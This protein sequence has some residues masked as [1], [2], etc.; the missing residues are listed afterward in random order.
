MSTG[1][2]CRES[3]WLLIS[4]MEGCASIAASYASPDVGFSPVFVLLA[5]AS[6]WSV[7]SGTALLQTA[8][9]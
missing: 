1:A 2:V 5:C 8:C 4:S 9:M 6:N 7:S 3:V